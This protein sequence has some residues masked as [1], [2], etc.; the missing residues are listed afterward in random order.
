[1]KTINRATSAVLAAVSAPALPLAAKTLPLTIFLPEY[2]AT[3]VGVNLAVVGIVFTLVRLADLIFDPLVGN[4]IDRTT[5]SDRAIGPIGDIRRGPAGS[6]KI[7]AVDPA[8]GKVRR[9]VPRR[10]LRGSGAWSGSN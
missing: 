6:R 7:S 9:G 3:K 5:A 2:Y 10:V 1:M 4:L 8:C